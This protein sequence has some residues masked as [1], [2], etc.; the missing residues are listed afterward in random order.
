[1]AGGKIPGPLGMHPTSIDAGT[2]A[3]TS[4]PQPGVLGA[5]K[6]ALRADLEQAKRALAM[7]I[8]QLVLDITG[9]IDP[10]PISDGANFLISLARRNWVDAVASAVSIVPYIGDLAKTAKLP[11]YIRSVRKA[12]DI[13][14]FDFR[15][16]R[17][18]RELFAKLKQVLD[19]CSKLAD[20]LLPDAAIKQL[21]ALKEEIDHFLSMKGGA[22]GKP[23]GSSKKT[24]RQSSDTTKSQSKDN[25]PEPAGK[26]DKKAEKEYGRGKDDGPKTTNDVD[27]IEKD[28]QKIDEKEKQ[29]RI[30]GKLK[31]K[32]LRKMYEGEEIPN[33]PDNWLGGH[34]HVKYLTDAELPQYKVTIQ[35]GKL[36]DANGNLFDTSRANTW[37]GKKRAIFIIDEK[38][39]MYVSNYQKAMEFHHSSLGQGKPVG[40]AGEIEVTNGKLNYMSNRSGHYHPTKEFMDQSI[41]HLSDQGLDFS[42]IKIHLE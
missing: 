1:M 33:N 27:G 6:T 8:G 15:W 25:R 13:A 31:T 2:L 16:A 17:A 11:R 23:S 4:M 14:R 42:S 41:G 10:T 19:E 29:S 38:G 5:D 3:R 26:F 30:K 39:D 32:P 18:L 22:T 28:R 24:G 20:D 12:I 9:I 7:D 37:D 35:D 34:G 21:K 36:Y 40:M